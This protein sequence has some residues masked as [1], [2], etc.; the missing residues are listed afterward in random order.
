[1][2]SAIFRNP[3]QFAFGANALSSPPVNANSGPGIT[4]I[5]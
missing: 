3:F 2:T 4:S 1:M 5:A